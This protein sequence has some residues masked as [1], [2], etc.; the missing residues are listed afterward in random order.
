MNVPDDFEYRSETYDLDG[1]VCFS[2]SST[3]R[4]GV[5]HYTAVCR[6]NDKLVLYNDSSFSL[7]QAEVD[8]WL[9]MSRLLVYSSNDLKAISYEF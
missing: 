7:V 4:T 9:K 3:G 6:R 1:A 5:G 2:P 8:N